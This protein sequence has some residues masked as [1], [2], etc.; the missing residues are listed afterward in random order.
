MCDEVTYFVDRDY[1]LIRESLTSNAAVFQGLAGLTNIV[2]DPNQDLWHMISLRND[3]LGAILAFYNGTKQ[4]PTGTNAILLTLY[5]A[6][7]ILKDN[8][9]VCLSHPCYI[10]VRLSLLTKGMYHTTFYSCNLRFM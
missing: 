4:F 7:L 9:L 6:C 5:A 2:Q 10:L 8:K 1:I 3:T